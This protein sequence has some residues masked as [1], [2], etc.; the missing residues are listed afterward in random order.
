M[1]NPYTGNDI[2]S[3]GDSTQYG[4]ISLY[5]GS[6]NPVTTSPIASTPNFPLYN[7]KFWNIHIGTPGTSGSADNLQF[8]AYQSNFNKNTHKYIVTHPFVSEEQRAKT[9]GDPF[10]NNGSSMGGA[11]QVFFGGLDSSELTYNLFV[12]RGLYSGSFQEI[13][14]HFGEF[15]SDDTLTKHALEPF[16][17]AGNNISSSF[18]NIVLRLPLG[19]ND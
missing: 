19:S 10:F 14:Y 13:R 5:S 11:K 1:I 7:G 15:L 4:K 6:Q 8:G 17:Y 2:S 9:F 3:S 12:R 18:T 16:M